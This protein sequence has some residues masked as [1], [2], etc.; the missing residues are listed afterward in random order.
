VFALDKYAKWSGGGQYQDIEDFRAKTDY[1]YMVAS[2][3]PVERA[4]IRQSAKLAA[5]GECSGCEV[6]APVVL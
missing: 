2:I 5:H 4:E 1:K 3:S 6:C